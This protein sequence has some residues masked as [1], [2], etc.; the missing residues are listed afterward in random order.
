M[1]FDSHDAYGTTDDDPTRMVP[2]PAKKK[3]HRQVLAAR[4]PTSGH[5]AAPTQLCSQQSP[6]PRGRPVL[7]TNADHDTLTAGLESAQAAHRAVPTQLS[8]AQVGWTV[9]RFSR[10]STK[11][12]TVQ[13]DARSLLASR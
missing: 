13:T 5:W 12:G 4:P 8:L 1:Y 3:A 10:V 6:P 9:P 11:P 7:I 2:N